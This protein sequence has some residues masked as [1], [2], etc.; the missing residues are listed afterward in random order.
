MVWTEYS[1]RSGASASGGDHFVPRFL[2]GNVLRG[3]PAPDQGGYFRWIIDPGDGTGIALALAEM[4]ALG[5]ACDICIQ[6]GV[7]TRG[8]GLARFVLPA[9]C[10]AWSPGGA[11]IITND[12]DDCIWQLGAGSTLEEM[13]LTHRGVIAGVGAALI[14]CPA[15]SATVRTHIREVTASIGVNIRGAQLTGGAF[16]VDSCEWNFTGGGAAPAGVVI[17]GTGG[18]APVPGSADIHDCRF[19]L[20]NVPIRLGFTGAVQD[21]VIHGNRITVTAGVA[22]IAAGANSSNCIAYGNVSRG[23]GGAIPTDAGV[24]NSIAPGVANIWGA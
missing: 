18:G 9:G 10:R 24:G 15:G 22:P 8:V 14:E 11:S 7:Y 12:A 20:F 16:E 23:G 1:G 6:E 5:V 17:Q 13:Q 2:V 4:A 21:S 19:S 3:A